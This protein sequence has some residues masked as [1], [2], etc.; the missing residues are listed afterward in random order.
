[1]FVCFA[2]NHTVHHVA[3][4]MEH[5]YNSG[6]I[7]RFLPPYSPDSN[8]IEEVFA[9]V[10]YFLRQN[11]LVLHSCRDA[12]LIILNAFGQIMSDNCLGYIHS[13]NVRVKFNPNWVK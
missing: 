4:V 13:K 9:K 8:P 12:C 10:K 6:P 11:D 7:V 1:M 3:D 5:I 2:D